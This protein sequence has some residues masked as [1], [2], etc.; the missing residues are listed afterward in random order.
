MRHSTSC[1]TQ[2]AGNNGRIPRRR[3]SQHRRNALVLYVHGCWQSPAGEWSR[4]SLPAALE[5]TRFEPEIA[6][7]FRC[8][9]IE[10]VR[11]EARGCLA[12]TFDTFLG[13]RTA[14][15]RNE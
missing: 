11:A 10:L 12:P 7:E 2:L 8:F 13:L 6:A 9:G 5:R 1:T 15:D 3:G 4:A 14:T